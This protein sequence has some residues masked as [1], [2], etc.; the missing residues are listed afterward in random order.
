MWTW[1][2]HF[3]TLTPVRV[4]G[5]GSSELKPSQESDY[6]MLPGSSMKNVSVGFSYLVH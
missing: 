5:A 2:F 4:G 3:I 1:L 6:K